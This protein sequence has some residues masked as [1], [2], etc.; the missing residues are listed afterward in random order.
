MSQGEHLIL[1][2][3]I[4]IWWV[5]Q[6]QLLSPTLRD[7]I[8]QAQ[9]VSIS[10]VSVYE[11]VQLVKRERLS[12][13]ID[14]HPWLQAATIDANI[15]VWAVST[16]IAQIAGNLPPIHGDPLDRMIIATSLVTSQL[17][18]SVDSK[19]A[20]YPDISELLLTK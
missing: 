1:D 5:N 19:F 13:A 9:H 7:R 2:T 3:H 18:I 15:N 20:L 4:W 6:D 10:S 14:L 11:L 12:L 16:Q 8:A 17:L